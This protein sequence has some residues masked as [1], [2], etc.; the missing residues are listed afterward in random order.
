MLLNSNVIIILLGKTA[1][2]LA[3]ES[4]DPIGRGVNSISTVRLLLKNG[5]DLLI[6]EAVRGDAALHSAVFSSCDPILIKVSLI[7]INSISR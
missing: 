1:L 5:A 3:V 2:H 6:K 4:H 7:K